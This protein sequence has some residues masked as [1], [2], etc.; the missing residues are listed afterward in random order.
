MPGSHPELEAQLLGSV[1]DLVVVAGARG[2]AEPP[3]QRPAAQGCQRWVGLERSSSSL[4]GGPGLNCP[5][6][7]GRAQLHVLSHLTSPVPGSLTP[8]WAV[9]SCPWIFPC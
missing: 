5:P 4:L 2:R 7:P 8:L 9:S 3:G 1:G 6:T